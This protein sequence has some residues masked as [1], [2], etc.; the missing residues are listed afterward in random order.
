MLLMMMMLAVELDMVLWLSLHCM[1]FAAVLTALL[2][3][4]TAYAA[5]WLS[6]MQG[7]QHIKVSTCPTPSLMFNAGSPH[8]HERP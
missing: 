6:S 8:H 4:V 5:W 1:H 7:R 2:V 3:V